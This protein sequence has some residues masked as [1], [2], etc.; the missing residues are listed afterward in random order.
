MRSRVLDACESCPRTAISCQPAALRTLGRWESRMRP[1]LCP[2]LRWAWRSPDTLQFGIDVPHP[3]IIGGLPPVC[4]PLLA[5]LD[6]VRT[7][8]EVVAQL[9][10]EGFD[11]TGG[12][13]AAAVL[14]QLAD[15]GVIVDGGRWPGGLPIARDVRERILPDVRCASALE[16]WRLQPAAR[17]ETLA[18]THVTVV[19]GS[20]LGATLSRALAAAG[21]GNV[22]I[23]DPGLVTAAD[24]SV[25]GFAP[26]DVGGRR[27][28]LVLAPPRGCHAEPGP[29]ASSAAWLS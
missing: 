12:A 21:V 1:M 18:R 19:G 15:L 10:A 28:D 8:Q 5:R 27:A 4:R 6:G 24:V 26:E 3:L 9:V 11:L 16:K 20:R 22:D 13:E 7:E 25:G 17:W 2:G 14:G 29:A 23:D